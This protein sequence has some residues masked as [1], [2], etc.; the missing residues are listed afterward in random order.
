MKVDLISIKWLRRGSKLE[1]VLL[2]LH[3]A[4]QN[5]SKIKNTDFLGK[6][7]KGMQY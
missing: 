1:T 7:K 5:P 2:S 4:S 3:F 6:T